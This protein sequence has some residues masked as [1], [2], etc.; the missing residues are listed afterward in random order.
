[1]DGAT[2]FKI[3]QAVT[4]VVHSDRPPVIVVGRDT[5]ISGEMLEQ[6]LVAGI[7]SMG[8]VCLLLGVLPTPGIAF[9]TKSLSAEAGFVVS[10]SH[11][12]YYDNGIKVF[13]AGG[14][15]LTDAIQDQIEQLVLGDELPNLVPAPEAIGRTA[16]F[17]DALD[18]Y[19]DFLISTFPGELNLAGVK[20][21]LDLG[22]GATFQVAPAVFHQLGAEV[23]VLHDQPNG[24]N[25][26]DG[27][28]SQHTEILRSQV[29]QLGADIGFAYDGDGDRLIAVD[30][31]GA[32]VTGDQTLMV[33]ALQLKAEGKLTDDLVVSTVMSNLGLR[34]CC[35]EN[36]ITHHA[37][38]VGDR[39]VLEAMQR[40]GAVIGGEDSGHQIFL[41]HHTT[42]DGIL[43]S[44]QLAACLLK[45]GKQL[46]ELKQAMKVFPQ[47]LIN[48]DV[49]SKPDLDSLPTVAAATKSAEDELGDQGR[50]LVRYSGTQQMCRVMIEAPDQST[51]QRL[52]SQIAD[53]IRTTIG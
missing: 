12:P 11:N 31:T 41:N 5:R 3:G 23:T 25:I 39:H 40:L 28:G 52:A 2:A 22:H 29:L 9:I 37:T 35:A 45:T 36:G 21:C 33:N 1:M 30:E 50:V 20:I 24:L 4:H 14:L 10:A 26:N 6:A 18:R 17:D 44:L 49:T 48:I 53:A 47:T 32:E 34:L 46:S 43:A 16:R 15:K 7:T 42:G 13:A 38:E 51:S 19:V 27:V 8:G